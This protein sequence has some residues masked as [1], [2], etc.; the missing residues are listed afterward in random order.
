MTCCAP[1]AAAQKSF[2][3]FL[4]SPETMSSSTRMGSIVLST[5]RATSDL[6]ERR[7][8]AVWGATMATTV[9][10]SATSLQGGQGA[11]VRGPVSA[12]QSTPA[13]LDALSSAGVACYTPCGAPS[14]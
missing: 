13:G 8:T 6:R 3:V 1:P 2:T 5:V 4:P 11:Y 10:M 12:Q 9:R 7:M 14:L